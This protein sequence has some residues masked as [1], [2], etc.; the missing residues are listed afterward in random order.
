MTLPARTAQPVSIFDLDRTIT[1][2]G[3]WS[4]FLLYAA[5]RLNPWRLLL[6][7]AALVAMLAYK[8]GAISRQRL[9]EIMQQIMIGKSVAADRMAIVAEGFADRCLVKGVYPQAIALILAE[10]AAGRRVIIATAAH[11]FYLDALAARLG[12]SEV[13]GTGSVLRG[14]RLLAAIEGSNCYGEAKQEK[15]C[16]YALSHAIDRPATH[17]RFYSDHI[18]DLPSFFWADEAIAV[19]PSSRLSQHAVDQGWRVLDWRRK[20]LPT[21][22]FEPVNTDWKAGQ[23]SAG[24]PA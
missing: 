19:N 23:G 11:H 12:V 24:D 14:D 7:P 21:R 9:K 6:A 22:S 2:S 20:E 10:Q 16:D 4:P 3:T 1:H 17:V 18:S 15:I 13:I 8:A 5:R